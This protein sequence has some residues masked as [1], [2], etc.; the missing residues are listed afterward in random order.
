M[1]LLTIQPAGSLDYEYQDAESFAK[2]G[3]DYLKYDN[4]FNKGRFGTPEA[5]FKRYEVMYKAL[6]A[7]GRSIL[8]SLCS[9]G[10]DYT[11]AVRPPD[12]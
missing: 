12:S 7:T 9:W 3:I 2:W 1:L 5:S 11:H 8:Y 10:E 6:E 4:C